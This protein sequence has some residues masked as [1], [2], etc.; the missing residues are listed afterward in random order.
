[1]CI[2]FKIVKRKDFSDKPVCTVETGVGQM[3][4]APSREA[5]HVTSSVK[6]TMLMFGLSIFGHDS[7]QMK[8]SN[9]NK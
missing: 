4:R 9:T 7:I 8:P 2:Q 3:Q 1:M 6:H 5:V